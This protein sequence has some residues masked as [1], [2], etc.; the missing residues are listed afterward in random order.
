[1]GPGGDGLT[2]APYT[3]STLSC[4]GRITRHFAT[5]QVCCGSSL[6]LRGLRRYMQGQLGALAEPFSYT[7]SPT[8]P[9]LG[10]QADH[11]LDFLWEIKS[12]PPEFWLQNCKRITLCCVKVLRWWN[13]LHNNRKVTWAWGT[14]VVKDFNWMLFLAFQMLVLLETGC[15]PIYFQESSL[16]S[17]F[18]ALSVFF[19]IRVPEWVLGNLLRNHVPMC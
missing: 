5:V 7:D 16:L 14:R 2:E 17:C 4:S 1:M 3:P 19:L 13:S 8:E 9:Q 10:A 6:C 11:H 18:F 12:S 15:T